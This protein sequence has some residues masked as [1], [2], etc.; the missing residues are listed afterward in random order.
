MNSAKPKVLV[1]HALRPTSRQTTIDHLLCFREHLPHA[2]VQYLH[3]QQ[4]LPEEFLQIKP[5]I[6]IINY[7][8]LNYR[9]TPLWPFI[10][11][12]H[13][14]LAMRAGKTVAIA[15]DDFWANRLLDN[16]CI[17]WDIDRILTASEGGW[18]LLYPRSHRKIQIHKSLTGYSKSTEVPETQPLIDRQ[19]DLGQ[20]VREMPAHLG[21]TGQLKARQAIEF[22]AMASKNGFKVDVSTR[23]EDAFLG[24]EWLNF[25][26]SCRFTIGMKGGASVLDP[27]GLLHTRVESYRKRHKE[28]S[29]VEIEQACFK[30]ISQL[31]EFVAVSPRLFEAARVGTCQILPPANY[32][33]VLEPWQ[34]YIPLEQDL[35]NTREVFSAMKNIS[36]CQSIAERAKAVLIDSGDFD[37][38]KF[39]I[40]ATQDLLSSTASNDPIWAQFCDY[41]TNCNKLQQISLELHDVVQRYISAV[42]NEPTDFQQ[43]YRVAFGNIPQILNKLEMINWLEQ[44]INF[45]KGDK[46]FSR[47]IWTWRNI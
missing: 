24:E 19:I 27:Y 41:I 31:D 10:K 42:V 11:N 36:K 35:S 29:Y 25:L 33:N 4:P 5:D 14:K 12:R 20:R 37:Y 23:V 47:T 9:F 26:S 38:S 39:V 21:K 44:Q 7:D 6:L 45:A 22:G 46:G 28:A 34:H 17:N 15:Q 8:Y 16:W 2:D 13:R 3:F 18:E 43:Q 32:L 40:T 30:K 1:I